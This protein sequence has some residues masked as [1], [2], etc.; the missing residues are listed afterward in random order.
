MDATELTF[1]LNTLLSFIFGIG[2]GL[3]AW[4]TMKGRQDLADQRIS[5]LEKNDGTT[6]QR[7]DLLKKEVKENRQRS[8]TSVEGVTKNMHEM[9]VRIIQAINEI[10]SS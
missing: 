1:G 5:S 8:D 4:F 9:E 6:H 7:I 10:K 3:G 2:G